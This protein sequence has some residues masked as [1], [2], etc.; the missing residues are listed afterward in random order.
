MS[1]YME[2][3]VLEGDDRKANYR[4][5]DSIL[6]PL[7]SKSSPGRSLEFERSLGHF[8]GHGTPQAGRRFSMDFRF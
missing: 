4:E 5:E 3:S 6:S 2:S 7:P 1:D 8:E